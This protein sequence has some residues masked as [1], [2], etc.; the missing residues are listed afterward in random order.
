MPWNRQT[1]DREHLKRRVSLILSHK[2]LT[3]DEVDAVFEAEEWKED[4]K[5][6]IEKLIEEEEKEQKEEDSES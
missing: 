2:C 3:H 1:E 6:R 4:K 5:R